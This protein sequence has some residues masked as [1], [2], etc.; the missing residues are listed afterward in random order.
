MSLIPWTKKKSLIPNSVEC[1]VCIN[2][3]QWDKKEIIR[4]SILW[5]SC[6]I[7]K[8]SRICDSCWKDDRETCGT[9]VNNII[10]E[11]RDYA[12]EEEQQVVDLLGDED[13]ISGNL[14]SIVAEYNTAIG[15]PDLDNSLFALEAA[16]NGGS[17]IVARDD[18]VHDVQL[19]NASHVPTQQHLPDELQIYLAEP[20]CIYDTSEKQFNILSWWRK[21][22]YKF[23]ILAR[24][25]ALFLGND[26]FHNI[27]YLSY[28]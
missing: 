1:H 4:S 7:C 15:S 14:E 16:I 21:N 10:E 28:C 11:D 25:A 6:I 20:L 19:T 22:E 17:G 3:P 18:V 9:C 5:S 2:E 13:F 24:M 26:Y 8:H 12:E 23:P 27:I